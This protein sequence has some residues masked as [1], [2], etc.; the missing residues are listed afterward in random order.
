MALREGQPRGHAHYRWGCSPLSVVREEDFP[1]S[2][3]CWQVVENPRCFG[4]VVGSVLDMNMAGSAWSE[5]FLFPIG[6]AVTL[7]EATFVSNDNIMFSWWW[8]G[9]VESATAKLRELP[10][11]EQQQQSK[12]HGRRHKEHH[13]CQETCLRTWQCTFEKWQQ[14]AGEG[15]RRPPPRA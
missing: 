11:E 15:P 12:W 2:L 5:L 13:L 6:K 3:G 8:S 9:T 14:G 4:E 1:N 10:A 7:T